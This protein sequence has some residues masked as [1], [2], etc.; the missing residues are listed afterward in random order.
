MNVFKFFISKI[1]INFESDDYFNVLCLINKDKDAFK[2]VLEHIV[3]VDQAVTVTLKAD[4]HILTS[5]FRF[6]VTTP[7]EVDTWRENG[8]R[9]THYQIKYKE[10]FSCTL[11]AEYFASQLKSAENEI[12]KDNNKITLIAIKYFLT[13]LTNKLIDQHE[14][15]N[16]E[17]VFVNQ[18][19]KN[20]FKS[21]KSPNADP[22]S[23][24][25]PINPEYAD[26][27]E[28]LF[29]QYINIIYIYETK[30]KNTNKENDAQYIEA[31]DFL[32][33]SELINVKN[34]DKLEEAE[35]LKTFSMILEESAKELKKE[36]EE[37]TKNT[38][39]KSLS[40]VNRSVLYQHGVVLLANAD[41]PL[42]AMNTW[43]HA[44]RRARFI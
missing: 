41:K 9:A 12:E 26:I 14:L 3:V 29:E 44:I 4:K 24:G 13:T 19:L 17:F 10:I 34:T 40:K 27:S 11:D 43:E 21:I 39:L 1:K 25:I 32:I 2:L 7:Q 33:K 5:P 16:K 35:I 28:E 6:S 42:A 18:L 8:K 20:I 23:T 36:I 30:Y 15:T 22:Q 38:K 37:K 31:V